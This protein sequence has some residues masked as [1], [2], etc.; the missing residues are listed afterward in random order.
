M[1]R[2]AALLAS[3]VSARADFVCDGGRTVLPDD[4][5]GDSYCDCADGTDEVTTG[6][7]DNGPFTCPCR[8][9]KPTVVF[10]SRVN[11]GVCDCCDGS[12][13]FQSHACPNTCVELAKADMEVAQRAAVQRAE[14]EESGQKAAEERRAR[15]AEAR[16]HLSAS[17]TELEAALAAKTTAEATEAARKA[18]RTRRLAAGEVAHALQLDRLSELSLGVALARLTLA[19]Q[20]RGADALHDALSALPAIT[21]QMEDVDSADL[22]MVAMEARSDAE[23]AGDETYACA[24][25]AEA[26]GHEAELSELL[27]LADLPADQLRTALQAFAQQTDQMGFLA[28]VSA[29]I[30]GADSA[31]DEAALTA[32]LSLLEP[33]VDAEADA[34]RAALAEL[35]AKRAAATK[36]LEEV[37]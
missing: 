2:A 12:D 35:E 31:A 34:A 10:A 1:L 20:V 11:D 32:A 36:T 15:Q 29:T 17:A 6:T 25:K 33:F 19:K 7:C 26:C 3:L 13:E 21:S 14:R 37:E 5:V 27:P 30:L 18:D 4:H 16:G 8:P 24:G 9:H 23:A 22:I 28:A